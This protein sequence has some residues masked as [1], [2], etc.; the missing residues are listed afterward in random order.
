MRLCPKC[1]GEWLVHNG[2]A[3]GQPKKPCKQC[4]DQLTR[5]TPRG[6]PVTA[7]IHAVLLS[8]RGIPM[9]RIAL[10]LRVFAQAMLHGIRPLAKHYRE[11]PEPTGK[12]LLLE[13]DALGHSLKKK[14]HTLRIGKALDQATGQLLDWAWGRRDQATLKK[15]VK[16]YPFRAVSMQATCGM[17]R[18]RTQEPVGYNRQPAGRFDRRQGT[19]R[20]GLGRPCGGALS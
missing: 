8:L 19:R 2:A 16:I 9:H 11:K 14:R 3:A 18:S 4:G 15:I 5:T 17:R 6:Q 1:Q 10:L 12:T 7:K 20:Q 13:L